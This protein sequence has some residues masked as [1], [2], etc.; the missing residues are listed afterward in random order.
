MD[1]QAEKIPVELP[2]GS[3]IKIEASRS[4]RED[5]S[6][7]TFDFKEVTEALEGITQAIFGTL[8]KVQPNKATVKFGMEISA[9]SGA[10][11]AVIVKGSSKANLEISLEW[12]KSN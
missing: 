8:Q 12:Q 6:S 11:T 3:V 1:F 10:L 2:N 9:D 4:G 5:I 7:D